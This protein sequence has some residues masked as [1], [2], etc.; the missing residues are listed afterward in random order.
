MEHVEG[1][2]LISSIFLV[3]LFV[4]G[5]FFSVLGIITHAA[6]SVIPAMSVQL[7]SKYTYAINLMMK[8]NTAVCAYCCLRIVRDPA[9]DS[10]KFLIFIKLALLCFQLMVMVVRNV[11]LQM[12]RVVLLQGTQWGLNMHDWWS[13]VLVSFEKSKK[14]F[15][16][17]MRHYDKTKARRHLLKRDVRN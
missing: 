11:A 1:D 8:I 12:L 3:D 7:P 14:Q 2:I 13:N 6:D 16:A 9:T 5:D 4:R 10:Y 15:E 17:D